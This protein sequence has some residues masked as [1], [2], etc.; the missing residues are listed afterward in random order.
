MMCVTQA[1]PNLLNKEAKWARRRRA[2]NKKQFFAELARVCKGA[3]ARGGDL[4]KLD[5]VGHYRITN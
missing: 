2:V 4:P 1:R 3:E 5:N